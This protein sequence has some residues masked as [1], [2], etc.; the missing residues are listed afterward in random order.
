MLFYKQFIELFAMIRFGNKELSA[1]LEIDF[2]RLHIIFNKLFK[3]GKQPLS[4]DG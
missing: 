2:I 4:I 3:I 1:T